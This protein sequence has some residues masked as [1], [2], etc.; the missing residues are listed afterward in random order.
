[1]QGLTPLQH[2]DIVGNL[3][4]PGLCA[5]DRANPVENGVAVGSGQAGEEG[6][7]RRACLQGG[8]QVFGD[9]GFARRSIGCVL[10]P[11]SPGLIDLLQT[12]GKKP[13]LSNEGFSTGA[14]DL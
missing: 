13:A 7:G 3:A 2:R 4:G 1:M 8:L 9:L 12:G 11:V 6:C 14:V 5:L 10:S